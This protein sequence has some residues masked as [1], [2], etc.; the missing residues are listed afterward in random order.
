MSNLGRIKHWL[1]GVVL[2]LG[3]SAGHG[4]LAEDMSVREW[5]RDMQTLREKVFEPL[6]EQF[7]ADT[8]TPGWHDYV[9]KMLDMA[10]A[11]QDEIQAFSY[12]VLRDT[13]L[14]MSQD[15]TRF[16]DDN[17]WEDAAYYLDTKLDLITRIL[18]YLDLD[19]N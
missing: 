13:T 6:K 4:V 15:F 16:G 7:Q 1:I 17:S 14:T 19:Q 2:L 9:V 3:L 8:T 12:G 11:T 18:G 10:A 5:K